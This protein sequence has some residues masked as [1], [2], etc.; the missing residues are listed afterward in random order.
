M[1]SNGSD[2]IQQESLSD[3]YMKQHQKFLD[4]RESENVDE[5]NF[6]QEVLFNY[7]T[8]LQSL[9]KD[10]FPQSLRKCIALM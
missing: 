9:S 7:F 1:H 4:W 10:L 3:L 5:H 2:A 8:H 6:S